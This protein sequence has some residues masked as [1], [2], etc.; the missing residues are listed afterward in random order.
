MLFVLGMVLGVVGGFSQSWY[1]GAVPAAAI[2]WVLVVFGLCLGAGRLMGARLAATCVAIG[3]LLVSMVLSMKLGSGDLV[4]AGDIAGIVYLYGGM[5]A[6]VAAIL[7][8][9]STGSWLLRTY[10]QP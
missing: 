7:L 4:I 8:T 1:V 6:I 9:P 2:A 3:W 10:R 5:A